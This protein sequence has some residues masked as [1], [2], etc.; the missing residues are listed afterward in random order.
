MEYFIFIDLLKKF[1]LKRCFKLIFIK[2]DEMFKGIK[3]ERFF[4]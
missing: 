4:K 2:I 3:K 1:I